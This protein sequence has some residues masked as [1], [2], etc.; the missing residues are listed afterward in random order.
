MI[1]TD[2]PFQFKRL[3]FPTKVSFAFIINKAQGQTFLYVGIDLRFDCFSHRQLY[4]DLSRTGD[5][6]N[7][8]ILLRHGLQTK[9]IVYSEI[10]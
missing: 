6:E 3:Q 2:L 5:S 1:P 10:I 4:V 9:N 7:Q 8:F